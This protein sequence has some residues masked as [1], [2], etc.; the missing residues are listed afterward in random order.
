MQQVFS[1]ISRTRLPQLPPLRTELLALVFCEGQI[2][3]L[4][5]ISLDPHINEG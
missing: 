5:P 2:I 3:C 1:R 4:V